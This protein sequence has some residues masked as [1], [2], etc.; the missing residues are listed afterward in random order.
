MNHSFRRYGELLG[1]YL[2]PHRGRAIILAVLLFGATGLQL[3]NP[4]FLRTFVDAA[5]AGEPTRVLINAALVY[6]AVALVR[7]VLAIGAAYVGND[8]GWRA[9]NA[10]RA[11]LAE[12]CL[13]LD[14]PFHKSHTPGQ[15]IE[16]IDG[17]VL[18]MANFFSQFVVRI[19][20][21]ALLL[22]GILIV[23]F[24]EDWRIGLS[25]TAFALTSL[26]VLAGL[27]E[28]AVAESTAEREQS[29]TLFGFIEERLTSIDDIRANG[30]GAYA[31]RRFY[32]VMRKFTD[33]AQMAWIKRSVVWLTSMALFNVGN[34]LAFGLG[35]ALYLSGAVTLGTAFLLTNYVAM[36]FHPIELLTQ[37]LQDLQKAAA[38][39]TRVQE[40]LA[41]ERII[42]DGPRDDLPTGPL[43]V[44]FQDVS[45]TYEDGDQQVLR[46]LNFRLLP[47]TSVGLLGRTGSGKTTL[48]RLLFRL[49]DPTEGAIRLGDATL[50]E[51]TLDALRQRV[52]MVT[53]DVQ[54][55]QASIRDN[56]T[57]FDRSIPDEE[58]LGIIKDLGLTDW[59]SR[60]PEGLDTEL[61]AGGGGLSAGEAQLLAFA[62]V[63]LKDPGLVILDEPSSRLDPATERLIER[64]VN[65]LLRDRTAIIIAHRLGTVQRVDE[66]MIMEDGR[67]IEHGPRARLVEDPASH[68][69][70]LL[71]TG[72]EESFA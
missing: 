2:G 38:G 31:M 11:D 52:G 21:S 19:V 34:V 32:E 62:R 23:L 13:S 56:L 55:F 48:S 40:L 44:A 67:I 69:S 51:L 7:R 28:H 71:R 59:I 53:Q 17:D 50:P 66:I 72:M 65:R 43:A 27:R 12:H 33:A 20:G 15:L 64:A 8:L 4:Q 70:G 47:G 63:F 60:Q 6:L 3:A 22:V 57:L 58:I 29:A 49:Y 35:A 54:L 5:Q 16:R 18:A 68:F 39:L 37:Q 1:R 61:A 10:L 30:A 41:L 9:T 26:G 25:L 46:D 14:L 42:L 36:L 24:I 45:F